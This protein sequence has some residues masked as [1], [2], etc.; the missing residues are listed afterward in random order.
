MKFSLVNIGGVD[1]VG[2][3]KKL[4]LALIWQLL[5]FQQLKMLSS[6]GKDGRKVMDAD[7]IQ[8]ANA[9][10]KDAGKNSANRSMVQ[11][12][13]KSLADSLYLI[14]LVAA[15]ES[16]A[17]DYSLVTTGTTLDEKTSNAKYVL[18]VARKIGATV[19]LTFEDIL[20]VKPK[21]I[22]TFVATLMFVDINQ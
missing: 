6:L 18:S 14:D 13:D 4:I 9:K 2:G 5:R 20:E 22:M 19:F 21:M 8:W 10:V 17:V 16:R 12:R 15:I 7:I 11:F 1:I 3:N